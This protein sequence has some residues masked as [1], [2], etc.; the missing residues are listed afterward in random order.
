MATILLSA[1][2]AALGGSVGGAVAGLSSV[3]IGRALG[4][5]VGRA[6]DS[7]LFGAG[8]EPVETGRVERFR[9]THASDGQPVA[10]VFG[11]MRVGGQVIW[12]SQFRETTT[13]TGGG[14][15]GGGA[16]QPQVTSY[17]Y[18][19]SLAIAVCGGEITHIG[20]VWADGEEVAPKDLNMTVYRGT[21]DQAPDP[22]MEAIEGAGQVPAYR[23]TAYV[24]ME[25]LSLERFGNRVPQFSFEVLRAEQPD[26]SSYDLD[27]PQLVQGVALMPGTGEYALAA[28]PVHYDH[29][30]GQAKPANSHSPSGESDLVTSLDT[31]EAELPNCG[32]ASLIVSWFGNDLR[33]GAC[34]IRPKVE[35]HEVEGANMPWGVAGIGRAEAELIARVEDRPIY[36][37]TPT[38]QAEMEAIH[39]LQARG[40]RVMF[41]PFILMDQLAGNDLPDPW[42]GQTGQPH[43]PWR[44]RITLS[45][46][47]GQTG[48]P[49]GS[50]AAQSEVAAFFGQVTAADFTITVGKA[51]QNGQ[52]ASPGSVTYSGDPEDW[53]LARF[54]LHNAALCAAA[55]GVEA[56]CIGSEMRALTQIR[57]DQGF[58]AVAALRDLTQQVR[59]ILGAET[60]IGYAADWSEY[61]GYKSPEG[62]RYFHLDPLWADP[63]IDFVGIDNYMPLS[64]W[65]AGGDHLDAEAGAPSIYDL[66]Y[67]RGGIEGGEGY[68]WY[69]HSTDAEAAQ[70]RTPITDGAHD[71]AWVWRYKDIRNWWSNPHHDRIDG[72]RAALPTAWEPQSKPIWFT[73]LGCAAIDK[74][75]NQ[76]NKF[77]DPKSSESKLPKHSDGQRDDLMQLAYLRAVLGYWQEKGRNPISDIYG[78]P[79]LD[80]SNA[81][82]WAW[83]ARPFPTF[84][85]AL[86]IWSDG[87]NY[88]RGHWLNG[89]VG[90]RSLA[91]VLEEICL[92]AGLSRD[93]LALTGVEGL[94]RGYTVSDIAEAR[95]ALQP[96]LLRHG[97]D[98]I[99]RDGL[100]QFRARSGRGAQ[101]LALAALADGEE[102]DGTVERTRA[103]QAE[104]SGRVRLRFVDW[105]GPHDLRVEEAILPD[106]ATHG[107][108][109]TEL[110]MALT[111]TEG[112]QIVQ[113]WLSEARIA[114]DSLRLELPPSKMRIG[115]GDVITLPVQDPAAL[116]RDGQP[117]NPTAQYRIDRVEQGQTQL[118]EAVRIDPEIYTRP[119]L[120]EELPGVTP[121]AAPVPVLPLFLDLPLISGD[122]LPHAPHLA[123]VADPWPGRVAVY[124]APG[125]ADY[126][127]EDILAA[128]ATVGVT[129]TALAAGPLGRWDRGAALEVDLIHGQLHGRDPQAVLNGANLM[130]IGDGS[131][132]NWEL[133]QFT[134][135]ELIAPGRYLLSN[136]LRGLQGS[137]ARMPPLWP[138][139]S[140][141]VAMNGVPDQIE[142]SANQR[143]LNRHY[144]IGSAARP[145]DDPSY[146]HLEAAFGG[147][148]LRPYAPVH[149]H[150][151]GALGAG[152]V[153]LSWIRRGRIDADRWEG[154]DIPLGE[155]QERYRL[156]LLRGDRVLREEQLSQPSWVYAVSD[157]TTD[158]VAPGDQIEVAQISARYGAGAAGRLR[159]L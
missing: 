34:Q 36:G 33:C 92:G 25:N 136:R 149:L 145:Y 42:T 32:A 97:V 70:I 95:A 31:L 22:V 109:D 116:G 2:G 83:D 138:K 61:W 134:T 118:I 5:T 58:P 55:G 121:F 7:R 111:R 140:Y 110:P 17:S 65:R 147:E 13:T 155:D 94:V 153:T 62:N 159:L 52:P 8:S 122:E 4:A 133:F 91:S 10:Q 60:K 139:G 35:R 131:P 142:L 72:M 96:L 24:V 66:D 152:D 119:A 21:M 59:Q 150:Q 78:G 137:D 69:Y 129:N 115:A 3:A 74:G 151:S 120:E 107:V 102:I 50:A 79:M 81:Y 99:E 148:G 71:E 132:A 98:A 29:G 158:A 27:L 124:A 77:L 9:L 128:S 49:D 82:V 28:T 143:G 47:P 44:G 93:A 85:N 16:R 113:R 19:V 46:A 114:R 108:S 89:R 37:G 45:V 156:R 56:F 101:P 87:E 123:V 15:K 157:Q 14:G 63:E 18:D 125:D 38:D 106:E 76:P 40:Q 80:M 88:L 30:P 103:A 146:T 84:P 86:G 1:A 130:A 105:G 48:S 126:G 51:A 117:P 141:V 43:L 90:Q 144:R 73:E 54:I 53:G 20:R 104:L 41:Y 57:D 67:L 68:E 100:L 23:G 26:S 11:R 154:E 127:L 75:S 6:I 39:A 112:R 12:A 64:D 135:A